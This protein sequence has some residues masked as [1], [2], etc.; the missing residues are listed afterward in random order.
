[1]AEMSMNRVIHGAFRRDLQRFEDAL[2]AFPDGDAGR[3]EQLWTAWANF[4]DQLTRHH[5]GEHE[6]AWP[7]LRQLG[8]SEDVITQWDAEHDRM[9]EALRAADE[10]MRTLRGSPSAA[11]AQAARDATAK[12]SAIALE[13]LDHEETELEPFYLAK[14]DTPEIKAMVRKFAKMPP[15]AAGT[16]FAWLQDGPTSEELA[17]LRRSVPGPVLA[18]LGGVFGR[19]YRRTIAPV[20]RA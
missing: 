10:A 11:N 8:L 9:A 5:V 1:M 2:A 6:I 16:F 12:L 3:A 15:P 19:T 4:D 17:N 18:I 7:T 20:W 14:K 13:H